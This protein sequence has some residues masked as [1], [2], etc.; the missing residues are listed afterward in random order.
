MIWLLTNLRI[1]TS[2]EGGST[3]FHIYGLGVVLIVL[4]LALEVLY[5]FFG[6][7][8]FK[9]PIGMMQRIYHLEKIIGCNFLLQI[10]KKKFL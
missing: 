3:T 8:Y 2:W 4:N 6:G 7:L 1:L 9:I 10:F 5:F